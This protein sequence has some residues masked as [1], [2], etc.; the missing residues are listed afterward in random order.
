[1]E[2]V[3]KLPNISPKDFQSWDFHV[4]LVKQVF[5]WIAH[6]E[7]QWAPPFTHYC[8]FVYPSVTHISQLLAESGHMVMDKRIEIHNEL[9]SSRIEIVA[10]T[11]LAVTALPQPT[12]P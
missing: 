12:K 2:H 8:K 6:C 10:V 7:A 9:N 3:G 11:H 1:M 5:V 4:L